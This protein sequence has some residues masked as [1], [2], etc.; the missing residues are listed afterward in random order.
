MKPRDPAQRAVVQDLLTGRILATGWLPAGQRANLGQAGVVTLLDDPTLESASASRTWE[1][2]EAV[3]VDEVLVL[4]TTTSGE[5]GGVSGPVPFLQALEA[6]LRAR[7]SSTAAKSYTRAL[8]DG[9][10]VKVGAKLREEAD[11][12]ACALANESDDRVAN[13]AA[14]VLYH[15]LVGLCL[16]GISFRSVT[17]ALR[18]RTGRSGHEEKASRSP[19]AG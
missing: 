2:T 6:T 18:Q 5:R 9:G 11:E 4:L 16:R 8:L 17:D 15:L 3:A 14:D 10:A 19:T 1:I 13:E 12:L 7:S